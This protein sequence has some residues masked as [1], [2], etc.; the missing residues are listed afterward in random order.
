MSASIDV[1]PAERRALIALIERHLPHTEVWAFG[2]RVKWN[3][4]SNSDLDLVAFS[5]PEDGARVSDLREALEEG[6]LPFRVDLLVWDQISESFRKNIREQFAVLVEGGRPEGSAG[7]AVRWPVVR[8]GDYVDSSLGKML[9]GEKNRGSFQKYLGNSNVRWGAFDLSDLASMRFEP[10]EEARYALRQ[11]DLVVCEGGEPGRCALWREEIPG[12]K[13]QKALHRVR[14]K[15][16]LENQ[17]LYYWFLHAGNTGQLEPFFTG[18]TIKHLTGKALSELRVPLPPLEHQRSIARILACLDDKIALNRRINQTLEA[19]AQA[20]FQSWFVD[21]DP[22]KAKVAARREGRDPLR[23]AMTS[24]S[25]KADAD[26]DALPTEEYERLAITAALFPDEM[27]E[28]ELGEIPR[29]WEKTTVQAKCTSVFSGGTPDTRKPEYWDGDINWFSSGETRESVIVDTEK[30]ISL[31]GVENSSTRLAEPDD[32]LIAS[33]GQGFTR[34]Q[35][36]LC[37]L[38]TYVNQSVVVV[39]ANLDLCDPLWL[40]CNLRNRYEE[41]R[42]ISDSHSSRGSLTTKLLGQMGLI[43]PSIDLMS[44]FGEAVRANFQRFASNVIETK[45]LSTLRDSLLPKLL[46]GE[47]S[48]AHLRSGHTIE[49]PVKAYQ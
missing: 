48:V 8:L 41:M 33:A 25:G 10:H 42:G 26:L 24:I 12:M 39:R 44:V 32:I 30:K 22:V 14:G 29:G 27:Q 38:K 13:I 34:G 31:A 43:C 4:R 45:T 15:Q 49:E 40:F 6:S 18:T 37:S 9:D 3:A 47:L 20:L 28:S 16:G 5:R 17:Y 21:F 36:S 2:S 7:V 11:G 35:T 23:A 1:G 46:S 19:L